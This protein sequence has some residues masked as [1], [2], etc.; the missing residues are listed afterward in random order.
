MPDGL[1]KRSL[2]IHSPNV[3]ELC[4]SVTNVVDLCAAVAGSLGDFLVPR[5]LLPVCPL[6]LCNDP[7]R[8]IETDCY[9]ASGLQTRWLTTVAATKDTHFHSDCVSGR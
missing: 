2:L 9:A 5:N 7:A 3:Q 4:I 1:N 8:L 6:S